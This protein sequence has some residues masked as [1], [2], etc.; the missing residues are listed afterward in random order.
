M[1][2]EHSTHGRGKKYI[3]NF[4]RKYMKGRDGRNI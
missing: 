1:C 4:G 2:G 3:Q